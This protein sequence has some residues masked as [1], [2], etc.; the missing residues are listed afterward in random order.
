MK[1][2]AMRFY[3]Q[4]EELNSLI[5]NLIWVL[6]RKVFLKAMLPFRGSVGFLP[7]FEAFILSFLTTRCH[8]GDE[9]HSAGFP[10]NL[11]C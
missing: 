3:Y 1:S 9:I 8:T 5:K 10:L 11:Y 2:R 4:S 6:K 7:R